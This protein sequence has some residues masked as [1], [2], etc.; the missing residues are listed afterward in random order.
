MPI[1]SITVIG[2]RIRAERVRRGWTR[3]Q[4]G[5]K[6][7]VGVSPLYHIESGRRSMSLRLAVRISDCLA[8]SLDRLLR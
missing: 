4:M 2:A 8:M 3:R 1:A 5:E 6:V 7:N